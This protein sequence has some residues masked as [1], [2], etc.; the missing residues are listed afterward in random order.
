MRWAPAHRKCQSLWCLRSYD[1]GGQGYFSATSLIAL[2][3]ICLLEY[4]LPKQHKTKNN[5]LG[6][7]ISLV[8]RFVHIFVLPYQSQPLKDQHKCTDR[9]SRSL[10]LVLQA[11]CFLCKSDSD[12]SDQSRLNQTTPMAASKPYCTPHVAILA[13]RNMFARAFSSYKSFFILISVDENGIIWV[14]TRHSN[15]FWGSR[16]SWSCDSSAKASELQICVQQG[17]GCRCTVTA[18]GDSCLPSCQILL[19]IGHD[20]SPA[21]NPSTQS[22]RS[23]WRSMKVDLYPQHIYPNELREKGNDALAWIICKAHKYYLDIWS[24]PTLPQITRWTKI[25]VQAAVFSL[26]NWLMLILWVLHIGNKVHI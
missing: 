2:K 22:N 20:E 23:C 17:E 4:I 6:A 3:P 10:W 5:T 12:F 25:G 26:Q 11:W 15:I 14:Q 16:G 9:C 21:W 18:A 8:H 7:A 19:R 13:N 24:L 1:P